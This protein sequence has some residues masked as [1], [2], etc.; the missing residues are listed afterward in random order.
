[1]LTGVL[2]RSAQ[3][4]QLP[5]ETKTVRDS[6]GQVTKVETTVRHAQP[7]PRSAMWLLERTRPADYGRTRI[8]VTGADGA[9]LV[10]LGKPLDRLTQLLDSIRAN[11]AAA[12]TTADAEAH[13]T[14]N[15]EGTAT[16]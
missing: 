1:M 10:D 14:P 7:D 4:H 9:P 5:P 2:T 3:G 8:E 12:P 16:P 13:I 15:P 11:R 6:E